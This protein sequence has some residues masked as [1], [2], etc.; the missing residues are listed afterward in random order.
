MADCA[1]DIRAMHRM[2]FLRAPYVACGLALT[3]LIAFAS[4]PAVGSEKLETDGTETVLY[5]FKGGCDGVG[6][7]AGMV[8][9]KAGNFYGTTSGGGDCKNDQYYGTVFR[10]TPDGTET[11]L[12][13]FKGGKDG[14][15]PWSKLIIDRKGNLFGTTEFGGKSGACSEYGGCGTVF[16]VMPSGKKKTLYLFQGGSDG[17]NPVGGLIMDKEGNLYGTTGSSGIVNTNCYLGC[18]TVFKI[19]PDRT[20]SVLY[21]FQGGSD[22]AMPCSSL[23]ADGV[24]NLYGTTDLGGSA[25]AGTVFK[26]TPDGAESVLHA[27][28]GGIDGEYPFG[29]VILDNAGNLYGTTQFGGSDDNGTVFKVESNGTESVLYSFK[30]GTDGFVPATGLIM[31][32]ATN[33]YGTTTEG[34]SSKCKKHGCGTVFKLSPGGTETLLTAFTGLNNGYAPYGALLFGKS[35]DLYGTTYEGGEDKYGVVFKVT[36]K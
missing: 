36:T 34:G 26:V 22:G 8:A 35:G 19:A 10:L 32:K 13:A 30:G 11:V 25:D 6:P 9:D 14:R 21:S 18:G 4:A 23:T 33:L 24:G 7:E 15:Q 12:Y 3:A 27:F 2:F 31:D 20:E 1:G 29:D 28:E 5:A 16:E 17:A